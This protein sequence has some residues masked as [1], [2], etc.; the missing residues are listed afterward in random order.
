LMSVVQALVGG[1][2]GTVGI[3]T[4]LYGA[5][6]FGKTTLAEMA[7]RDRR[8][9]RRFRGR[10][11]LVAVGR[12]VRGPQKIAAK[13]NEVIMRVGGEDG[14]FADPRLAGEQLGSLLDTG[15]RRL[16]ILDDV[17]EPEQ[18]APFTE[19]GKRCVRLVTTRVRGLLSKRDTAVQVDQM[20]AGQARA[21]LMSGLPQLDPAVA[22]GL[23]AVTGRWP[24]LLR[25]VNKILADYAH[26]ETDVSSVSRQGAV[27]LERL[28]AGGPAVVDELLEDTDRGLDVVLPEQRTRAVR[29]TVGASTSLLGGHDAERFAE[30]AVFAEDETIPFSL[31]ARLWQATAGLDKLQAAR[32]ARRLAQLALVSQA[33]SPVHGIA[34]HDVVRDFLRAEPG[35]DRLASLAG[36][37]LDAVAADL[38]AAAPLDPAAEWPVRVAWW[39]L[40]DQD[41]Y[42]WD[43]LVEHLVDAGRDR[44]AEAVAGDL[45]WVA[46]RLERFGPAAPAA[47]LSAAG[48][49]LAARLL[50]AL[51][52]TVPL[53]ARTEPSGAVVD[54]LHSRVAEDPYWGPQV[55]ALRDICRRPRLVN[56]WPLPDL[57]DP[58]LRRILTGHTNTVDA[59]AVAPD[60]SWLASGGGWTVR[61]WD[62][63]TGNQRA[64]WTHPPG[65]VTAIVAAPDGSWLATGGNDGTVR[66]WDVA[67]GHQRAT[68]K[69]PATLRLPALRESTAFKR[70]S[71]MV[72]AMAVAPDGSWLVT[73]GPDKMVR[74][75]DVAARRQRATLVGPAWVS[76][77]AVAP[78]GSWLASGGWDGMVRIWD[79]ATGHQRT[80]LSHPGMVWGVAVVPDGSW[81]AASCGD[82]TVRIWDVATG[83]ERAVLPG[84]ALTVTVAPDGS[85]LATCSLEGVVKILDVATG[86]QRAMLIGPAT[87]EE[88]STARTQMV[89]APDGSWLA[90]GGDDGQVRIWDVAAMRQRATLPDHPRWVKAVAVAPDGSW[91]ATGG[92]DGQVRTWDAATREQ[93]SAVKSEARVVTAVAVAPDG[94]WLAAGGTRG[95]VQIW[96]TASWQQ[97][98]V[99]NCHSRYTS[100]PTVAAVVVAPD[101]SWLASGVGDG[102]VRIWDV[103][104]GQQRAKLGVEQRDEP[105]IDFY[106]MPAVTAVAVAP[107][108][109]WLA[110][111]GRDKAVRIWDVATGQQRALLTG[112]TSP[113]TAV[114]AAPDGSWLATGGHDGRIRIWDVATGQQRALLTGHTG[115]VHA[116]AVATVAGTPDGRWLA[117]GGGDGTLQI[118]DVATWKPRALMRLDNSVT[119]AA[120]IGNDALAVGG[121]AGLYLFDFLTDTNPVSAA[122]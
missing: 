61:V 24:L 87:A 43:H 62:M 121:P 68:L 17:W 18:L 26:V 11:Y 80:T 3:T 76:A 79:V 39:E 104:T 106:W 56:R 12:D 96:D 81:V 116:P 25:L 118:W 86:Q 36:M 53:L 1:R 77:V 115:R 22:E 40:G 34:V 120:W 35:Q 78:D 117:S 2:A 14:S 59:M 113:V 60:G 58:A 90:T 50:A 103:A 107:D 109:S 67:T 23:L 37:L 111:A 10:V 47:D 51:S 44:D 9:R 108:G 31:V 69:R 98:A 63:A 99:L 13:V 73:G 95:A 41:R 112:H 54:V 74:I 8:V 27:L 88:T 92:E 7:L 93:Q 5:G 46:A 30:L 42:L 28:R 45:R 122:H 89:M 16:L 33:V 100:T 65:S 85:W 29:A 15:P 75:W 6:G 101:G 114:A 105:G 64:A 72:D 32:V 119:A 52:P 55:T 84:P 21:L 71:P 48:T 38:P 102:T 49:M 94:S 70:P 57:A 91:L 4:G 66:I 19:G 20:S 97:R 82:R 83:Q 110:S